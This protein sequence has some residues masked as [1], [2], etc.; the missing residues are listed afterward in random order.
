M[1]IRPAIV[2]W[3][4]L[5][6]WPAAA[7]A[8]GAA[9]DAGPAPRPKTVFI[10][11]IRDDIMPPMVYLVRRG[12]KEAMQAKADLLLI[13]MQTNGGRVDVTEEILGI[14]GKFQGAT[15]TYVNDRAF[16]AG[17]FI[18]VATQKIYMAPGSVIGAAAPIMMLPGGAGVESPSD[19]VEVKMT[20]ALSA[21][22]RA[23]AER[24]GHNKDVVEAMI[25]KNKR[26]EIDGKVL[27]EKGQILT[28]TNV[29]AEKSFGHPPKPLLSLGTVASL[30]ALLAKLGCVGANVVRIRPT[31][32]E[33]LASWLNAISPLLLIVGIV[34]LYLE[35]KTPG[36]GLPGIIGITAFAIYFL[37]GYVAGLAGLEWAAVFVLG[38]ALVILELFF[39]PGSM[40]LGLSG[41]ALMLVA[42][43]MAAVDTYPGMPTIPTLPQLRVPLRDLSIALLGALLVGWIASRWLPKTTLYHAMV[44]ASAS[45][46]RTEAVQWQQ[47]SAH[48]GRTGVALST[49]RPSGKAQFGDEILDVIS[50]GE[51]IEQGR[52]VKIVGHSGTAAIVAEMLKD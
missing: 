48:L 32:A 50:Q 41:A 1:K 22:V 34:A 52:P 18:A 25:N 43:V 49:L 40:V 51:L 15:V 8:R 23:C 30:D 29:E 27:N 46:T 5:L 42:I 37:G 35:F 38:L 12:V 7:P 26:L 14:L 6:A 13:D 39:F 19:T 31:G 4:L 36:F 11:P 17:A 45:G 33:K 44:S 3:W 9:E 21:L 2:L 10:L 24:N 47:Q 28:L 20:S 16:S